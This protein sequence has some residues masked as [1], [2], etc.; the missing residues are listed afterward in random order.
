MRVWE[1]E[2]DGEE[3]ELAIKAERGRGRQTGGG[4]RGGEGSRYSAGDVGVGRRRRAGLDLERER[5]HVSLLAGDEAV[6]GEPP[7]L[8]A[9][10]TKS[11]TVTTTRW[12]EGSLA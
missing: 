7:R 6:G 8:C 11:V 2:G 10:Q 1:K 3:E 5:H 9:S 4:E 12:M